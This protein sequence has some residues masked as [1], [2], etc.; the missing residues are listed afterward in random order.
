MNYRKIIQANRKKT[1]IVL[2]LY[3]VLY[4]FV[5]LLIDI[6]LSSTEGTFGSNFTALITFERAPIATLVMFVLALLTIVGSIKFFR[7][8]LL[9][10]EGYVLVDEH[11][12]EPEL[13]QLYNILEELKISANLDFMPEL[14][15]IEANYMNAF[16]SGWTKENSIVAIT[17]G[18]LEKL[19]RD[20]TSAVIA[21]ELSHI[22]HEDIKLTLA[23]GVVTNIVLLIANLTLRGFFNFGANASS[24]KS[25]DSRGRGGGNNPVAVAMAILLVL[26]V[27]M[28]LITALLQAYLSRSREYMADSGAVKLTRNPQPLA[29]ALMKIESDYKTN[30][31]KEDDNPTRKSA[32]IF[33]NSKNLFSTHPSVQN[34]VSMLVNEEFY[35]M[36]LSSKDL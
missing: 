25:N 35:F 31:Y 14:Y 36:G 17:R 1:K 13:R 11:T 10:K 27:L 32:Y 9:G 34:R 5:G 7:L 2:G 24:F 4:A 12:Q 28:P 8:A 19:D 29:R 3:V 33:L 22:N 20:E 6:I 26:S 30:R 21:H 18:L 23:V 16:A 15:V